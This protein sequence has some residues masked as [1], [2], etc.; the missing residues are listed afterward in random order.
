MLDQLPV[1]RL[2]TARLARASALFQLGCV[3]GD[4]GPVRGEFFGFTG[5]VEGSGALLQVPVPAQ[6]VSEKSCRFMGAVG[7]PVADAREVFGACVRCVQRINCKVNPCRMRTSPPDPITGRARRPRVLGGPTRRRHR[8]HRGRRLDHHTLR[9][10]TAGRRRRSRA[11]QPDCRAVAADHCKAD[12]FQIASE[13][14]LFGYL[15]RS[16]AAA[17]E[18]DSSNVCAAMVKFRSRGARTVA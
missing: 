2:G 16:T 12:N 1:R 15:L 17:H 9:T 3:L 10:G 5:F 7:Y 4:P 8:H 18:R 6:D 13:E 14:E 11:D